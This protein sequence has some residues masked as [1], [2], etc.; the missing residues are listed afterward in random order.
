M[1]LT[2]KEYA[3]SRGVSYEAVRMQLKRYGQQLDGFIERQGRTQYLTDE[4]V[5]FLDSKRANSEATAISAATAMVGTMLNIK[6]IIHVNDEGK[7]ISVGKAR[8]RKAAIQTLCNKV[9]ELGIEGANDTIFIC[10]GD[11]LEDA[12]TLE[13]MLKETY[14]TKN[15]F[16]HYI[17]AV[18]G[19]H[20]GPGT[21]AVFFLGNQR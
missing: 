2:I 16:I 4:A 3:S 10:H 15:V 9:G 6:P 14:G 5:A 19:A 13:A 18:I 20:T 1:R 7:L 17:G 21:M 11:C 12:Q 8:G